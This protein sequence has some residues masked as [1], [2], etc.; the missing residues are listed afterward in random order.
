MKADLL[1]LDQMQVEEELDE[2]RW[3]IERKGDWFGGCSNV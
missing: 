3:W 1:S 2:M